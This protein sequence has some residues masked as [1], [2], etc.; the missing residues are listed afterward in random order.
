MVEFLNRLFGRAAPVI[1]EA[2]EP[3]VRDNVFSSGGYTSN[4]KKQRDLIKRQTS[5]MAMTFQRGIEALVP[6]GDAVASSGQDFAL[7]EM[8]PDLTQAKLVNSRA[9]FL[10]IPQLEWYASQGFIGWQMAAILSQNWLIDKA[11]GVPAADAVRN[12]YDI[13]FDDGEKLDP[14][15]M[16]AFRRADKRINIKGKTR[17][18]IKKGRIFGIRH[19]LFLIDGINYEA[20]FNPDGIRPGSYK[21]M[22]Q[23]DPYWMA[24]E[25]DANAAANPG[26]PEFYD[27]TWWRVNNQKIHKSH[28]IITRCGDEVVDLLKPSYYYGG[29]PLPQKL[30]NRVYAA[31][32]VADEAP[33]LAMTKRLM[34]LQT[35]TT[36]WFG[37]NAKAQNNIQE[38]MEYQN[39]YSVKVVGTKDEVS[40]FDTS[41]QGL[42]ETIMT[43]FQLVASAANMPSS[44]LLGTS[45]KGFN[46]TGEYEESNYHEELESIQEEAATPF[47]ERH[48]L[49]L[50]RSV[51]APRFGLDPKR[52]TEIDWR[53]TDSMTAKE[54][55]EVNYIKSQTAANY[56]NAGALDGLDVRRNIINDP[57][58][59]FTGIEEV[60]DGGPGDREAEAE[61][62]A[63]ML[64]APAAGDDK[65][66]AMDEAIAAGIMFLAGDKILLMKRRDDSVNGGMWSFPAG[67][68]EAGESILQAACREFAEE[69]GR[70]IYR[71]GLAWSDDNFALFCSYGEEF[72]PTLCAE[73]SAYVWASPA[74]LPAPLHPGVAEQIE[75]LTGESSLFGAAV[76]LG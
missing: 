46:A 41:L 59:G 43:Q 44:K 24:P 49:C 68:V 19:A 12:G 62:K 51:I 63:A 47:I 34:T 20:P 30:Y 55:A 67:T 26:S 52:T 57:Q 11:C 28:F 7:D 5:A 23:I 3:T 42:D 2:T 72:V 9:G 65:E 17:V 66:S 31:E 32:R 39:N 27:P 36:Q 33:M 18:F 14:D 61:M 29:I 1:A 71:A 76:A 15:V 48:H 73:H 40:Q 38:W 50:Y 6:R 45:P 21:G 10:P 56:A 13:L 16:N 64:E 8:Y 22:V 60:V 53:A 69:T 70:K 54:E 25:L 74:E 37:P 35:D 75:L 4:L 58:S